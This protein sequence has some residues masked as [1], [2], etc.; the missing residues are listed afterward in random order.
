VDSVLTSHLRSY[1][2][3][4]ADAYAVDIERAY[5]PLAQSLVEYASIASVDAVLDIGTGSGL[6]ARFASTRAKSVHA[7]DFAG[8][9]VQLA[10][11][12]ETPNVVQADMHFLPYPTNAFD[13]VLA[14][15][16]FNSTDP[17]VSMKEASRVL[18]PGRRLV[19]HE[20][21]SVDD[22]SEFVTETLALYAT[23]DPDP[24]LA[25]FR[26]AQELDLP[27]DD[28]YDVDDIEEILR[29]A[30]FDATEVGVV[31]IP[32]PFKSIEDFIGYKLAWPSR[33]MEFEALPDSV[34]KLCLADLLEN[35]E[36]CLQEDGTFVWEPNIIRI[37][38]ISAQT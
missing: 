16:A 20:W 9:M 26:E 36:L 18:R 6:A 14:A 27:W 21:G 8:Q 5:G 3:Q 4:S 17:K 33:R 29:G 13:I 24:E 15:F 30:G 12:L 10:Y 35:L 2:N 32:V 31:T 1:F 37:N 25:D 22:I 28:I 23:D 7:V 38:A 19:I 11:R 34:Q